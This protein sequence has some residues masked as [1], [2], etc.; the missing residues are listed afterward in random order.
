MK[1]RSPGYMQYYET[2]S[3]VCTAGGTR[4]AIVPCTPYC[5]SY[6]LGTL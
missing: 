2:T 3:S 6:C 1:S 4:A 5:I